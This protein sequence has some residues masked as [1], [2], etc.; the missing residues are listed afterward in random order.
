[1]THS[2]ALQRQEFIMDI[3]E[4]NEDVSTKELAEILNV[5]VWTIRRDLNA[6]EDR[7]VLARFYGGA[8]QAASKKEICKLIERGSFRESARENQVAKKRISLAAA[9]LLH[10]GERVALT[11]GTTTYEVAKA[12]KKLRFKG[13]IVTN[14]LDI[15]LVLSEEPDIHVVCTG[16]DVQP[17]YHTLVGPI[18]ERILKMHYFDA[19]V[20]G[21]SG[22]SL[23]H[24]FT[25]YSQVNATALE[26]VAEHSCRTIMVADATKLGQV[27]FASL[28]LSTHIDT[29]VTD[30]PLP[31]EYS[32]YFQNM[33]VDVVIAERSQLD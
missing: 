16:G 33:G 9:R 12:L 21:V 26:L 15:A 24:G 14:A 30:E 11:G 17:R 5:S 20:I 10:P 25:V 1:M 18:S 31:P 19:A 13:E 23:R 29:F 4:K 3:L 22:I 27:S 28:N 6:L 8:K 32:D 7:K 2:K